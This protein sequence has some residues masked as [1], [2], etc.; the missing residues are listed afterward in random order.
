MSLFS[1]LISTTSSM[2]AYEKS[3]NVIQ[4]NVSNADSP[5]FARQQLQFVPRRF[6]PRNS[7]TG[8]VDAGALLS[9]RDEYTERNLWRQNQAL[10]RSAQRSADLA[11]IEP[12]F[13]VSENAGVGGA[14]NSFF[15]SVSS[16]SINPNDPA[17]RQV[18]LERA[19]YLARTFNQNAEALGDASNAADRQIRNTVDEVNRLTAHLQ[20]LNVEFR[21]DRRKV[22]D[23]GLDADLHATL[24]DLSELVD[25]NLIRQEDGSVQVFFGGQ[26]PLVLG[27]KSFP[28]RSDFS[29]GLPRLLDVEARDVTGQLTGG[30]LKGLFETRTETIPSYLADLDTLAATLA[31]RVNQTLAAGVDTSGANPTLDLFTYDPTVGSALTLKRNPLEPGDLAGAEAYSPGGNGNAL[32]LTRLATSNEIGDLS[33]SEY[34]GAISARAGRDLS[35]AKEK[36]QVQQGLVTQARTLRQDRSGVS[37]DEEAARLVEAQRAYQANAQLFKVLSELTDTLMGILR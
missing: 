23:A 2:Q 35:R 21:G 1:T 15:A 12:F 22:E 34:Y 14:L 30:R 24:E 10:G 8:G 26:T 18:V 32:A 9:S 3:L 13:P 31:D 29:A 27:D 28:L 7:L 5:A 19:D 33:F 16:W 36:E 11:Q 20:K 25:F 6:D 17:S 37:L 4:N